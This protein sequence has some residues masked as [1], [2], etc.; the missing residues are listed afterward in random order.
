MVDELRKRVAEQQTLRRGKAR[1]RR[2]SGAKDPAEVLMDGRIVVRD[3]Y[4]N[5]QARLLVIW[6]R[7][8][9]TGI[10]RLKRAPHPEPSLCALNSPPNSRARLALACRPNPC[11]AFLVV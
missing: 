7:A 2:D 6:S 4:P 9:G 10:R 11:P 3:Q 5:V 1:V 8:V